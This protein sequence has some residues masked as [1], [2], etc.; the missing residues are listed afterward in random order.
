MD[1]IAIWQ[2]L[3]IRRDYGMIRLKPGSGIAFSDDGGEKLKKYCANVS[4]RI[5]S[6]I[7]SGKAAVVC[8]QTGKRDCMATLSSIFS[9]VVIL[10]ALSA[11][12]GAGFYL[13]RTMYGRN[14]SVKRLAFIERT[15]LDGGRKLLLVR[16]DDVEHLILIGGP[17]DLVVETGI[18]PEPIPQAQ[19]RE[20]NAGELNRFPP[21]H[22]GGWLERDS[23]LSARL[24]VPSS[25]EGR[26]ANSS[27]KH[28]APIE[29]RLSLSPSKGENAE[30]MLELTALHEAKAVQ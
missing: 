15:P 30:E 27:P 1:R 29:P 16:R 3:V 13:Y 21:G 17:I 20:G 28:G 10:A 24:D 7:A 2:N 19:V 18:R 25:A 23:P 9:A 11:A 8:S 5:F 4:S 26:Q 14:P 6:G 12:A 22:S